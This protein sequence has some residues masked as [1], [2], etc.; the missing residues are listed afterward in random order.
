[1]PGVKT[2]RTVD[3]ALRVL[4]AVAEHQPIGVGALARLLT[5]DKSAVQRILVSLQRAGWICPAGGSAAD[6]S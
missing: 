1:M 5:M 3:K 2:L 4:D 6:G